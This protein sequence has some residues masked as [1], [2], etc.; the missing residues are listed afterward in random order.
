HGH[1]VSAAEQ[2]AVVEAGVTAARPPH[3]MM[4]IAP[5][6]RCPTAGELA[7]LVAQH[8][9][10]PETVTDGTGATPQVE[11]LAAPA[12]HDPADGAVA[13]HALGGGARDGTE[14]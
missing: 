3:Q 13:E 4:G 14:A 12:H 7:V 9:R 8:D 2:E 6:C 1:R 10:S 5:R 11:E